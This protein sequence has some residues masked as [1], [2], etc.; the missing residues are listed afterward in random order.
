MLFLSRRYGPLTGLAWLVNGAIAAVGS[1]VCGVVVVAVLAGA[2][3]AALQPPPRPRPAPGQDVVVDAATI[4]D[5]YKADAAKAATKYTGR[6]L[7]V[8]MRI[9]SVSQ[10]GDRLAIR[11]DFPGLWNAVSATVPVSAGLETGKTVTVVGR[12][13]SSSGNSVSL[14]SCVVDAVSSRK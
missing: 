6:R 14:G 5:D 11:Q 1:G 8:T 3:M 13:E 12:I 4:H 10:Y 9:D 2:E 7:R